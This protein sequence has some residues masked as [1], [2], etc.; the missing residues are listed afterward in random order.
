MESELSA[1]QK[2]VEIVG[3]AFEFDGRPVYQARFGSK[4]LLL[5]R[6]GATPEAARAMAQ[7]LVGERRVSGVISIGMAGAAVDSLQ[8]GDVVMAGTAVRDGKRGI[9]EEWKL[10]QIRGC[11]VKPV[12]TITTVGSFVASST[13]R[14]RLRETYHAEIVDMSAAEI[15]EACAAQQVPCVIIREISDRADEGARHAFTE[16]VR[17]KQPRTVHPAL[18]AIKQFEVE[19]ATDEHR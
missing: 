1:L 11:D 4:P 13:E 19:Q 16:T 15:A 12:N 5:A 8:I 14:A 6:T 3:R 17:A 10:Q 9:G 2:E 18:C 7:W